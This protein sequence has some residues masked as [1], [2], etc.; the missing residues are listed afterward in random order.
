MCPLLPPQSSV[1][2]G[3]AADPKVFDDVPRDPGS[4][5]AVDYNPI[6]NPTMPFCRSLSDEPSLWF[7]EVVTP[8]LALA[9]ASL[10]KVN[11]LMF[12]KVLLGVLRKHPMISPSM[13]NVGLIF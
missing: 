3:S 8:Q 11:I 4:V 10:D 12:L 13:P 1:L 7:N 6:F 5:C 9:D 2:V